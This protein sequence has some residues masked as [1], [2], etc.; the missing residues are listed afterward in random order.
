M[1]PCFSGWWPPMA[2]GVDGMAE[3]IERLHSLPRRLR[4]RTLS[5]WATG[6][7][8][9]MASR[10]R[11]AVRTVAFKTGRLTG[12]IRGARVRPAKAQSMFGALARAIAYSSAKHGGRVWHLINL[13]TKDRYT[14]GGVRRGGRRAFVAGKRAFRGRVT[15]R[16]IVVGT[17]PIILQQVLPEAKTDLARRIQR[18][19]AKHGG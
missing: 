13:G 12:S 1:T 9:R 10:L 7:A 11:V 3:L 18:A 6:V 8:A 19:L 17:A 15:P 14:K 16:R 2:D 4:D 5:G